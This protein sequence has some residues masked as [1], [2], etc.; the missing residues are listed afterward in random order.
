[1]GCTEYGDLSNTVL[2]W[3]VE[4][5]AIVGAFVVGYWMG[6]GCNQRGC[7]CG[8]RTRQDSESE[9]GSGTTYTYKVQDR[10]VGWRR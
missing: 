5:V 7:G 3:V 10:I 8:N 6:G 9:T 1:M 2:L 4:F